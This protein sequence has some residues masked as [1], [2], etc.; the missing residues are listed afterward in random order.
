MIDD[1]AEKVYAGERIDVE[2]GLRLFAHPN[3]AELGMLA[4]FVRR[5]KHP[6][7]VVSYNI[8]RNI[9]YTNVCWVKCDFC[10]FYRPPGSDEGSGG[11]CARP[12]LELTSELGGGVG[13]RLNWIR[14]SACR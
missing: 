2:E 6:E 8:G 10:A 3:L 12:S 14:L 9:N 7:D 5:Q 11:R 1:I 13:D 4:D